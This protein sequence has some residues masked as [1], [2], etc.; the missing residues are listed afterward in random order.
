MSQ[1]VKAPDQKGGS[2]FMWTIV[3]V[4]V[5]AAVVIGIVVTRGGAKEDIAANMPQE[6]VNFTVTAKDNV[7]E[8]ASKNVDKDAPVAD[9]YEDFSCP[10]CSQLLEADHQDVKEA[11][12]D[13][14][15][16]VRFNFLN[17][18]DDGRRGP[19]TRGAAVAYAIAE[20]GNV[21]AFWNFH[22]YT[23]L[24][25]ETVARTWDY[26]DLAQAAS[27]YDLDASLIEKIKNGE[28]ED[29]GVEVGEANAKALKKKV[30]KVSSPVV[31]IDGQQFDIKTDEDDK[32]KSWV[33]DVVKK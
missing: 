24:E 28:L 1:K 4:L 22:N 26:E 19:S 11:V 14:K 20:T 15:L 3:A 29:K 2:G 9:I 30:G 12:S 16:K 33:P 13:G 10:Y 5:I 8:L 25:Q 21:K 31:L 7:V 17:F 23:M 27:A 6:D 18:L 32:L